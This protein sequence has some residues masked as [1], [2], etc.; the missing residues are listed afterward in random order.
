MISNE[1]LIP[2]SAL[3]HMLYCPRQCALI[4]IERQ[5]AENQFTAEGRILHTRVE[6][7]KRETQGTLRIERTVPLQ[8]RRLGVF[9]L[10]MS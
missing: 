4:H 1:D 6:A 3:Q 10:R 5:W 2:I 7:G 8:S 9:G